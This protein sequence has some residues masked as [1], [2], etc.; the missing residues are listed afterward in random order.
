MYVLWQ[1]ISAAGL[2]IL[3][4]ITQPDVRISVL[5]LLNNI[6][7][8]KNWW[9][10]LICVTG[11]CNRAAASRNRYDV[12]KTVGTHNILINTIKLYACLQKY[13]RQN[14]VWSFMTTNRR[15]LC[16]FTSWSCGCIE[17]QIRCWKKTVDTHKILLNAITFMFVSKKYDRQNHMWSFMTKYIRFRCQFTSW[18]GETPTGNFSH[19]FCSYLGQE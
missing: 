1:L 16:T 11:H 7:K 19:V 4:S 13:D 8:K 6:I 2:L 14:H 3:E 5:T 15:C 9:N 18:S 10:A 17:K 12:E